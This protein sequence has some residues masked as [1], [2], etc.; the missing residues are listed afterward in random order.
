MTDCH[1]KNTEQKK[2]EI[3]SFEKHIVTK[4][5]FQEKKIVMQNIN[6]VL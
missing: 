3:D 1:N 6:P 5:F 2:R 4:I